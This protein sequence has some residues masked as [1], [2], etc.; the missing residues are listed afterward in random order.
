M[1]L[2]AQEMDL[3]AQQVDLVV[4]EVYLVVQIADLVA[5]AIDLVVQEVDLVAQEVDLEEQVRCYEALLAAFY[6]QPWFYGVYWWKVGTNGFG[7]PENS[8][9]T[10]WRKPAMDVLA[11]WYG[12]ERRRTQSAALADTSP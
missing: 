4:Q 1:G 8:S 11:R 7:G 6:E 2:V 3:V 10:P 9:M 12:S 5:E